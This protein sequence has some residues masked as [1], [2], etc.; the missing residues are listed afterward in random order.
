MN[1]ARTTME[2]GDDRVSLHAE[3]FEGSEI[4]QIIR[5]PDPLSQSHAD[6]YAPAQ[7]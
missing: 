3:P 7:R 6:T 1:E 4:W 2:R 5:R